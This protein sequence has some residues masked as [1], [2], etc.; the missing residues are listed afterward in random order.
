[1]AGK[2][3][4]EWTDATWNPVRGCSRVS[5]GC[6]NCYAERIATRFSGL[7]LAFQGFAKQ[8]QGMPHWIGKVE[9]LRH[10]LDQPMRLR[11]NQRIFVNS[12]SDLFH[13]R[14][15]DHEI[16]EVFWQMALS[17]R[18]TFQV[19]T[20][21]PLRMR[22]YVR[23][24]TNRRSDS[25]RPLHELLRIMWQSPRRNVHLGVSVED[26]QTAAARI[27]LLRKTPATGRWVSYE[28]ALG[29]VNWERWLP[30]IDWVVC[31]GESGPHARPMQPEWARAARDACKEAG[32][33]FFFKQWGDWAPNRAG[34]LV[35]KGKKKAGRNL[36][37][38]NYNEFPNGDEG[39]DS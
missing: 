11:G 22:E 30:G 20:K 21:R 19:L 13:E 4:I 36:D 31:G 38:R 14:L 39:N 27:P 7:G 32:V 18:H 5:K 24:L 8:V 6:D 1:M 35:H 15:V 34:T 29:P 33:P 3:S 10:K 37:G 12:M 28:P 26:E 23:R 16:D 9:L 2:T 17:S 25:G